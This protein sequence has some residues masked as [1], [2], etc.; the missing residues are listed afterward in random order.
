MKDMGTWRNRQN[1]SDL[2]SV[3]RNTV[4]I[5]V[6]LCL[7]NCPKY[8]GYVWSFATLSVRIASAPL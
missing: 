7:P 1:A 2:K 6:P 3:G 4:R 8:K 5:R